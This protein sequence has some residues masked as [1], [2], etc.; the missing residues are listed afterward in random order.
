MYGG[1]NSNTNTVISTTLMVNKGF[2]GTTRMRIAM[3]YNGAGQTAIN[4]GTFAQ[5]SV[6]D[7]NLRCSVVND[8]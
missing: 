6:A 4:C 1:I 7:C 3:A 5:G 8:A 2:H